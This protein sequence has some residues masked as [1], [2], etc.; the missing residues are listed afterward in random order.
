MRGALNCDNL[1]FARSI[2]APHGNAVTHG[3]ANEEEHIGRH[4]RHHVESRG[5]CVLLAG[6]G[7]LKLDVGEFDEGRLI[8]STNILRGCATLVAEARARVGSH[9]PADFVLPEETGV[10][11][12][13]ASTST[14][15]HLKVMG[16]LEL[17]GIFILCR[18]NVHKVRK[19][20]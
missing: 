19:T 18:S 9:R 2:K 14:R 15:K 3:A 8:T 6:L 17:F 5:H 7:D 4:H 16:C 10:A 12:G 1:I 20:R 11:D 13:L